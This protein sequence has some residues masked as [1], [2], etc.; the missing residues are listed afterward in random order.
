MEGYRVNTVPTKLSYYG[1]Q[2]PKLVA[3]V[4]VPTTARPPSSSTDETL[5]LHAVVVDLSL[6]SRFRRRGAAVFDTSPTTIPRRR[7]PV[8]NAASW[9]R[10]L[11]TPHICSCL[12]IFLNSCCIV[13]YLVK[14]FPRHPPVTCLYFVCLVIIIILLI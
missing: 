6:T 11:V 8:V 4:V 2:T 3:F 10:R 9:L 14:I 1:Y 12:L 7:L 5:Q 13:N